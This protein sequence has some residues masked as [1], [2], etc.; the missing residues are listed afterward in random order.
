MVRRD[1][2]GQL[3]WPRLGAKVEWIPYR[4]C[5]TARYQQVNLVPDLQHV[6]VQYDDAVRHAPTVP[7]SMRQAQSMAGT[8]H[9]V[10]LSA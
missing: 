2:G 7:G 9:S 5:P 1:E 10:C 4:G 3:H 6:F 8:R